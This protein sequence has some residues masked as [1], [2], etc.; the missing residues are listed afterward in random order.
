MV[1]T[2]EI[3][4]IVFDFDGLV[5]DT[6]TCVFESWREAYERHGVSLSLDDW[7]AAIG[8][9]SSAY[10]PLENLKSQVGPG[11]DAEAMQRRRRATRDDMLMRMDPMP[12]I[13]ACLRA[14]RQ[15]RLGVAVASSSPR[16]WVSGHLDRIGL[17]SLFDAISAEED[18]HSVKPAPDV[19]LHAIAT[20]G[21]EP[22]AAIAIEDSPNGVAA[23]KAAGLRCIAVPGPMTRHLLFD[24]ADAVLDTL[25]GRPLDDVIEFAFSPDS[26]GRERS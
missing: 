19:Y 7:C 25:A 4:A 26:G 24:Q 5:L 6:E 14:A 12:G 2:A 17:R 18:V 20:L 3:Q 22:S 11:F 10:D 9:D 16:A 13:S 8:T 23:A 1:R 15:R 21:V